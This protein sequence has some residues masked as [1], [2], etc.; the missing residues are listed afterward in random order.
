MYARLF[1]SFGVL[2]RGTRWSG[3]SSMISDPARR[4]IAMIVSVNRRTGVVVPKAVG[5]EA[6]QRYLDWASFV[7][8]V[9]LFWRAKQQELSSS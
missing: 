4:D 2:T 7:T 3:V 6:M 9:G 1:H 8:Q 5:V